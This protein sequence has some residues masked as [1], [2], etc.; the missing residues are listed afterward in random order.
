MERADKA[1]ERAKERLRK[2]GGDVDVLRANA[3]L[4]RAMM[5]KLL[6]RKR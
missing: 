4:R 1:A 2:G 3:A 6:S 5:R